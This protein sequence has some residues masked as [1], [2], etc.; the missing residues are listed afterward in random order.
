MAL[1]FSSGCWKRSAVTCSFFSSLVFPSHNSSTGAQAP[2][3]APPDGSG[4][5]TGAEMEAAVVLLAQ[6]GPF[7]SSFLFLFFSFFHFL[8][9]PFH[10]FRFFVIN[11]S[12]Y[13]Y[14]RDDVTLSTTV[15]PVLLPSCISLLRRGHFQD[16]QL[17]R[18]Q[19]SA[20]GRIIELLLHHF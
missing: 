2:G 3:S 12:N 17:E 7:L 1:N 9:F 6:A 5:K 8:F 11:A 10:F 14:S 20:L 16:F 13:I 4:R 19:F 18:T 15:D